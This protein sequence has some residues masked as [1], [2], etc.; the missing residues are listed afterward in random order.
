MKKLLVAILLAALAAGV[1]SADQW[2][3]GYYR[4][5]GTYVSGYYRSDPDNSFWNNYSSWGNTNPYTGERGYKLPTLTEYTSNS[6]HY[7]YT[8]QPV[9]YH[10]AT[11][12]SNYSYATPEIT[13]TPNS[14]LDGGLPMRLVE[15]PK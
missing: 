6:S 10:S 12:L 13:T 3:S 5:N 7:G 9:E 14:E 15:D 11:V 8:Y 1:L 2:V 4:S